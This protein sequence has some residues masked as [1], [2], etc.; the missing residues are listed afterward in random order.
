VSPID[1]VEKHT[2]PSLEALTRGSL[3][4]RDATTGKIKKADASAGLQVLDAGICITTPRFVGD[5][6]TIVTDGRV[7]LGDALGS[8]AFGAL[9]Y[10]SDTVGLLADAAGT[11]S[12]PIGIVEPVWGGAAGVPDR[13]LRLRT[14]G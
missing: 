2:G 11:Q 5:A 6:V 12:V 9:V 8:M 13:V 3:C 7:A 10:A 4:V 1:T 14:T